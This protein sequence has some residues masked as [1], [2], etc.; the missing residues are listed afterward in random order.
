M[1]SDGLVVKT[2]GFLVTLVLVIASGY[3]AGAQE[4]QPPQYLGTAVP[5][6]AGLS[7][8]RLR[9]IDDLLNADI[10]A[11][12]LPGAVLVIARKGIVVYSRSFGRRDPEKSLPMERDAIFRLYSM[13]KPVTAVAIM[14][15][16]EEGR[17]LLSDPVSR[18]LPD[19]DDM[20]VAE[21]KKNADGKE[22]VTLRPPARPM[23]ILD[24]LRHT[25]GLSYW[26]MAPRQVRDAYFSEGMNNLG[27]L[28]N[29]D[30]C[31]RIA[32]LPLVEDP[33]TRYRYSRSFHV[34]G[35]VVEEV[36]GM[37][38]EKYVAENICT[39]L[40]MTD[41]GFV[42]PPGKADRLVYLAPNSPFYS[43]PTDTAKP[44]IGG[45]S[46][47]VGTAM[48]FTRFGQMLLNRGE[49][50]GRRILSVHAVNLM[51]ADHLGEMGERTDPAYVPGPGYGQGFGLYVRKSVGGAYAMGSVGEYY[52][53]GIGGTIFWVDPKEELV[54][55][56]MMSQPAL[57]D[58]YRYLIK[59]MIYQAIER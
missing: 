44:F 12:K 46:A 41:T 3:S 18:Y 45:G 38:L 24:L 13:S 52:K 22:A 21:I 50:N 16:M 4:L 36:A 14:Q 53:Q 48:D 25:S 29:M 39:P 32:Q 33:G 49:F 43:D 27:G 1:K 59:N 23:T 19:F 57:R 9:L 20:Q 30:I 2:I 8:K 26:F 56:F 15:L 17:L 7:S 31:G 35:C 58:H 34:L 47:M 37:P 54:A 51:T 10:K 5:E 55:V 42:V 6:A 11:G 40:G 28:S